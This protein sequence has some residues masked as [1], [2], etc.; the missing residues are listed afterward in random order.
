MVEE[1]NADFFE[2]EKHPFLLLTVQDKIQI[3]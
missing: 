1:R 2:R 3:F